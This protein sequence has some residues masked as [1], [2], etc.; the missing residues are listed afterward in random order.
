MVSKKSFKLLVVSNTRPF[1]A[2]LCYIFYFV[3]FY[4][5][6]EVFIYIIYYVEAE[7]TNYP[8]IIINYI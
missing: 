6:L 1:F 2:W 4:F 5:S 7:D 3:N 8:L